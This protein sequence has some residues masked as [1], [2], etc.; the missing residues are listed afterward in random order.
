MVIFLNIAC[1]ILAK[2]ENVFLKEF[3]WDWSLD[4]DDRH[5]L[6]CQDPAPF[7]T[8]W[9]Q[10]QVGTVTD[11]ELVKISVVHV[12]KDHAL[13]ILLKLTQFFYRHCMTKNGHPT[14]GRCNHANFL[15][16]KINYTNGSVLP[17]QKFK[18]SFFHHKPYNK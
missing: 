16:P 13:W 12:L 9:S 10:V 5:V 14:K 2:N 3:L 8:C 4:G 11:E 15:Y 18:Y 1:A 17:S 6:K 7:L